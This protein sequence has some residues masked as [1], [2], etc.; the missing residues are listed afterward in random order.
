MNYNRNSNDSGIFLLICAI[1]AVIGL[2]IWKFS[3]FLGLDM[4]TG[5]P[6][7]LSLII[8]AGLFIVSLIFGGDWEIIHIRKIWPILLALAWAC[9]WPALNYW[10]SQT[11]FGHFDTPWWATWYTKGGVFFAIIGLGYLINKIFEDF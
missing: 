5:A 7:F 6:V 3:T 4:A 9:F 2:V 1:V 10:S 8:V 11:L